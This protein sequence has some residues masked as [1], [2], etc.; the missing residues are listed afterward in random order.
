MSARLFVSSWRG[1]SSSVRDV[2]MSEINHV[3]ITAKRSVDLHWHENI[4]SHFKR[5]DRTLNGNLYLDRGHPIYNFLFAYYFSFNKSILKKYSPGVGV[6]LPGATFE[7]QPYLAV[8]SY[9]NPFINS[10]YYWDLSRVAI[11][12]KKKRSAEYIY[13]I[14]RAIDSKS[15]SFC[16]YGLHEW[17]MLYDPS[18][19]GA[20]KNLNNDRLRKFQSLPLR[21]SV[22][23]VREVVESNKLRCTHFDAFRYFTDPAKPLNSLPDGGVL[24]RLSFF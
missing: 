1:L 2:A 6:M 8:S 18:G 10:G 19:I 5:L 22:E 23:N 13:N 24:S 20:A 15:P 12:V 4:N 14:L 3:Q 11:P 17:A 9:G 7:E 16:C 21:L